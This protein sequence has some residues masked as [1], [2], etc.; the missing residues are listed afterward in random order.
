MLANCLSKLF[1]SYL[2]PLLRPLAGSSRH[3]RQRRIRFHFVPVANDFVFVGRVANQTSQ[4]A[5][6]TLRHRVKMPDQLIVQLL[7]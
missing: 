1:A 6:S 3:L 7:K 4:N 2:P 5:T